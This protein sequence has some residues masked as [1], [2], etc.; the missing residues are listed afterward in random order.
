[1]LHRNSNHNN[2]YK[3]LNKQTAIL[4]SAGL[5]NKMSFCWAVVRLHITEE[6]CRFIC[7]IWQDVAYSNFLPR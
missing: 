7:P 5:L 2:N 6:E 1:M 4:C 3:A